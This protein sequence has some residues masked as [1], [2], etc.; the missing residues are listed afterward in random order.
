MKRIAVVKK[1]FELL[2]MNQFYL[3]LI[4]SNYLFIK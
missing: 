4:K 3:D 1:Y 2:V